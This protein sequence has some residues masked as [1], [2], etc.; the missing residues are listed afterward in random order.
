[1]FRHMKVIRKENYDLT[2]ICPRIVGWSVTILADATR[3]PIGT[4]YIRRLQP[5]AVTPSRP[6]GNASKVWF[7]NKCSEYSAKKKITRNRF[8]SDTKF[9]SQNS[10]G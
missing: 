10:E 5:S 3:L 9:K 1:M 6:K 7:Y 4:P 8:K 2:F